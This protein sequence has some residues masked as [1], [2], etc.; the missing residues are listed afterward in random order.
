MIYKKYI[1]TFAILSKNTDEPE[2]KKMKAITNLFALNSNAKKQ[3]IT[4]WSER[5]WDWY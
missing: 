1:K 4:I 5:N 3:R 2:K